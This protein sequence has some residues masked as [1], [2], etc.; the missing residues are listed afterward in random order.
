MRADRYFASRLRS[1]VDPLSD[2]GTLT[3]KRRVMARR[4]WVGEKSDFFSILL[5]GEFDE[6]EGVEVLVESFMVHQFGMGAG[7][8]EAPFVEDKD[9]ISSLN[10]R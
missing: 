9:P 10:R 3:G 2:A 5:G 4:G 8:H 1:Y 7:F 6:S